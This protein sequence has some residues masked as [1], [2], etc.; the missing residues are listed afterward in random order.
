MFK[1]LIVL[2][3]VSCDYERYDALYNLPT[4]QRV[5]PNIQITR[6]PPETPRCVNL[7]CQCL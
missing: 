6:P 1:P 4:F 7:Q 5:R 2:H 3:S